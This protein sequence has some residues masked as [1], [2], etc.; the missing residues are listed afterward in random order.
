M[1]SSKS[2]TKSTI[3]VKNIVKTYDNIEAV[4]NVS[5]STHI[6]E[7]IALLGPNGAGKST[8]MNMIAGFLSPTSGGVFV[9]GNNVAE[10][11][12]L[13]KKDIGFLPE[14]APMYADMTVNQFLKY[15]IELKLNL[16][17]ENS[18]KKQIYAVLGHC[19]F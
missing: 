11:D 6:G 13:S 2:L 18:N 14:G 17:D 3:E 8:L 1:K 10:K 5:F 9:N 19:F 7:I 15:F 16:D 12:L 4:K